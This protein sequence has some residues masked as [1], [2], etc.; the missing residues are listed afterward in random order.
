[1]A[2]GYFSHSFLISR[3]EVESDLKLP[4]VKP[5]AEVLELILKLESHYVALFGANP[6]PVPNTQFIARIGGII[7]TADKG[8]AIAQILRPD[9][10]P[11]IDPWVSF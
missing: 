3:S 8:W 10:Q 11:V 6:V 1:L 2:G 4:V 9:G 5:E 7:Q